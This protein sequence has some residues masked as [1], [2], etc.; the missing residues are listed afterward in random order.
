VNATGSYFA[1]GALILDF[2]PGSAR[3]ARVLASPNEMLAATA[4]ANAAAATRPMKILETK[5]QFPRQENACAYFRRK[6][7]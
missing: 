3:L 1:A 7:G 6:I 2:T 4:T 5:A